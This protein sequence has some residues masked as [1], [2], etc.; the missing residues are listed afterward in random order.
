[1]AALL[2]GTPTVITWA[3]SATPASQNITIPSDATAVY[4]FWGYYD[5]TAGNGLASATL[6]GAS[7]SQVYE[8]ATNTSDRSA[9]G[10]AVW[11]NPA[12]GSRSLNVVWDVLPVLGPGT[13][14]AYIKDGNTTAWRDADAGNAN[15]STAVS[16]TLDTISGDL[17]LKFD[18]T[19]N[20][21]ASLSSGWTDGG[22][23]TNNVRGFRLSYIS[24]SGAIQVCDSEDENY[25]AL[26]AISIPVAA[27]GGGSIAAISNYYRMMRSA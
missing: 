18:S 5:S 14:V 26:V 27:A 3:A 2:T 4:M 17:V 12:T 9:T 22:T 23:Q 7:P 19:L 6:N 11:Y 8:I 16:V 24:A 13:I 21:P 25:S 20:G 1:M 10:V 15:G